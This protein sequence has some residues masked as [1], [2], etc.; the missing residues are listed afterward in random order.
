MSIS[1]VRV[2]QLDRKSANLEEIDVEFDSEYNEDNTTF[3]IKL[4][5]KAAAV[6]KLQVSMDFVSA[7]TDTLQGIY[8]TSYYKMNSNEKE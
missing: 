8:K 4:S 7:I 6:G 1:N 5:D 2:L 3:V